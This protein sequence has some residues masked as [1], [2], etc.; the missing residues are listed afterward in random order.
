MGAFYRPAATGR[1]WSSTCPALRTSPGHQ[2]PRLRG[3]R[4]HTTAVHSVQKIPN[5]LKED[6]H[7]LY[8]L[9]AIRERLYAESPNLARR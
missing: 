7:L 3:G 1:G 2:A 9:Q 8:D 6:A 5:E 4:D